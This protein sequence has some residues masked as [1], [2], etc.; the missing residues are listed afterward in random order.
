MSKPFVFLVALV[1]GAAGAAACSKH[2]DD[3]EVKADA[4]LEGDAKKAAHD[5]GKAAEDAGS[6]AGQPADD[7]VDA[8]GDAV[9]D[10]AHDAKEAA[11]NV[12]D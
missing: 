6:S 9:D 11:E 7:A 10:A 4:G 1:L 12:V 2:Q 3:V 8:V 5:T